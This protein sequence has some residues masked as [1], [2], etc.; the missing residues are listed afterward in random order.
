MDNFTHVPICWNGD[1]YY[2]LAAVHHRIQ[3]EN[4]HYLWCII[5]YSY[6]YINVKSWVWIQHMNYEW[7]LQI[8]DHYQLQ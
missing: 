2:H 3:F 1:K 4:E 8:Y 7:N 6:M 5:M